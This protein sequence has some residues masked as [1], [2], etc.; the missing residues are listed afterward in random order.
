MNNETLTLAITKSITQI[1]LKLLIIYIEHY[2]LVV[3]HLKKETSAT[4]N[5]ITHQPDIDKINIY[6]K[7]PYETKHQLIINKHEQIDIKHFEDSAAFL[8]Y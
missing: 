7:N 6:A 4:L 2:V 5:L 3:Q 8:E 1:G